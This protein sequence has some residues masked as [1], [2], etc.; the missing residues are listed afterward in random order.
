MLMHNGLFFLLMFIKVAFLR[1]S[2]GGVF[3]YPNYRIAHYFYRF[4]RVLTFCDGLYD[5]DI[6]ALSRS[7]FVAM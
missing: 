2:R 7:S 6:F 1:Q 4:V 3:F 5:D